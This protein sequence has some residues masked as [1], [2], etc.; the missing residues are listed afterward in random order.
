LRQ[1]GEVF[2]NSSTPSS[3]ATAIVELTVSTSQTS[4]TL[5][6]LRKRRSENSCT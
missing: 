3:T 1:R 4:E 6:E 2:W 5:T